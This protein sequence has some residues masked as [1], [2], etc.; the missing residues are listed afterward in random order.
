MSELIGPVYARKDYAGFMRRTAALV[1][2]TAIVLT[3]SIVISTVL[4][5]TLVPDG[6]EE[7]MG[8]LWAT[9]SIV[10]WIVYMLGFRLSEKGTPGYR[11]V[12]IRYEYMFSERPTILARLFRSVS[13]V[14]LMI[15]FALDH[16]WILFDERKQAWHDKVAGFYVVKCEARP[17]GTQRIVRRV[18]NSMA[19]TFF[20][21]EPAG[22]VTRR[23]PAMPV[24]R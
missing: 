16:I 10:G 5:L 23:E 18:F 7:E 1:L 20:V 14:A 13:A 3:A 11:I 24:Q 2:D 12:G 4:S 9:G 17:I 19:M 22:E 21:W 8:A 15:F 6:S